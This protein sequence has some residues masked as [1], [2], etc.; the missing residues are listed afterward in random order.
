MN[1]ID[2]A[3]WRIYD[4]TWRISEATCCLQPAKL[5]PAK[6]QPTNL[7]NDATKLRRCEHA[8]LRIDANRIETMRTCDPARRCEPAN[9]RDDVIGLNLHPTAQ[10]DKPDCQV[11]NEPDCPSRR[12]PAYALP[13]RP[14][15]RLSRYLSRY[16]FCLT[17]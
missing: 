10:V 14:S 2:D 12:L 6:L 9:L 3:T 13:D 8:N 4:A 16:P 11:D 7:R 15:R 1:R 5:Q 17:A